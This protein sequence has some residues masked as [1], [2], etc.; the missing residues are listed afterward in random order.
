MWLTFPLALLISLKT[1][2]TN[3]KYLLIGHIKHAVLCKCLEPFLSSLNF[4]GKLETCANMYLN[5]AYKAKHFTIPTSLKMNIWRKH[6]HSLAQS[7]LSELKVEEMTRRDDGS[8]SS[9]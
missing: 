2:G 1:R 4:R 6:L 9:L 7:D 5:T 3:K 8:L